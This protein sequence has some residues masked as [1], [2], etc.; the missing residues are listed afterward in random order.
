MLEF[1]FAQTETPA[2]A[3][4]WVPDAVAPYGP[5][6]ADVT[7]F[8]AVAAAVYLLGR[9][10]FVPV[11]LRVLRARNRNNPTLVTATETYLQV[12]LVGIAVLA[13]L[14]AAGQAGFLVDTDSAILLAALTFAFGVAGQEVLGSL[15]SGLFL[16]ADPDF[17]VGDYIS[18]SGGEGTVEAVDFRVTRIR[19]V[20][21]ETITV[22]NTELTTNALT[23]PFGR[24]SYRVKERV[25][26]A[27]GED[28]ERALMELRAIAANDDR[29][30]EEPT[31]TARVVDLGEN[32]ITVRAAFWVDDPGRTAIADVRSDFRRRIKRQFDEE[33]ITLAPPSSQHLSGSVEVD[34]A[35][36]SESPT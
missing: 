11:V 34:P 32:S 29:A 24:D 30:M 26:V 1:A 31:P 12:L 6:V 16:V 23:R 33:G 22:P 9:L 3:P 17:N 36:T 2:T 13:G 18:W 21:N 35:G 7:V 20:D 28:T 8:A 27:Y 5:F 10:L 15:V 25:F 14:A 19:T 4:E